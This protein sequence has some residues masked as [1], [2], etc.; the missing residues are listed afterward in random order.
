MEPLNFEVRRLS[1][2]LKGLAGLDEDVKLLITIPS[3]GYYTALL[4]KA[5]IGDVNH[6]RAAITCAAMLGLSH[7][8]IVA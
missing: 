2:D 6:S 4:V 8:S 1:L 3:V 7:Q 5:E